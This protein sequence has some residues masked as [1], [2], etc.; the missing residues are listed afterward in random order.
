MAQMYIIFLISFFMIL[1]FLLNVPPLQSIFC[2]RHRLAFSN[3]H[4]VRG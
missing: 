2:W 3:H 4:V 1:Y